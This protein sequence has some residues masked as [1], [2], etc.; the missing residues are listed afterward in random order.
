MPKELSSTKQKILLI[1]FSGLAL[2]YTYLPNRQIK[3]IKGV[4]KIWK[5]IDERKLNQEIKALY[6]SKLVS[7]KERED[8]T[9]EMILS[10]KGK[11]K[12]LNYHFAKMKINPPSWDKKW[13]LVIS[14]IP[15]KLRKLRDA[16]RERLKVLGFY[17][18]QKSVF[19]FPYE[20]KNEIDFLIEFF[21]L[22]KYVRYAVIEFI[23]NDL[24]LRKIFNLK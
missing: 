19:V 23:D 16:L 6:H 8:G 7:L 3:I 15:E 17:E 1:L 12:V 14:D 10:E 13:R 5:K 20:C 18:L 11:L 24:H 4:A 22:R 2:G 21:Q 9:F